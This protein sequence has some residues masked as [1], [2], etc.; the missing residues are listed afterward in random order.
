MGPLSSLQWYT[1]WYQW[2]GMW[3]LALISGELIN[4]YATDCYSSAIIPAYIF[5]YNLTDSA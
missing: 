5:P 4:I 3:Q 1:S 2:G